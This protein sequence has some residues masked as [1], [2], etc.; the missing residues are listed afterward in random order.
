MRYAD[1]FIQLFCAKHHLSIARC[2]NIFTING[3]RYSYEGR[4]DPISTYEVLCDIAWKLEQGING[5]KHSRALPKSARKDL[6]N[7]VREPLIV[8][9]HPL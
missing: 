5:R 4:K 2:G 9:N 3:E 7:L 8:A 1:I 6:M